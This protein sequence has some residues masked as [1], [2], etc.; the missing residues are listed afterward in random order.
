MSRSRRSHRVFVNGGLVAEHRTFA[1][2][3]RRA[4]REKAQAAQAEVHIRSAHGNLY[5]I[6]RDE[7]GETPSTAAG[8]WT[9]RLRGAWFHP[10]RVSYRF[11]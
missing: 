11:A 4:S 8:W 10:V 6:V 2:A 7:A 3:V 5:R 1:V 9:L